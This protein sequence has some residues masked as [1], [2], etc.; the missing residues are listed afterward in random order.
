MP[1]EE[2]AFPC[3]ECACAAATTSG[4][5]LC[6][7]EWMQKAARLT[8]RLPSTTSP[9][10]STRIRSDT[11]IWLKLMPNGLTQNRSVNS[12]SRAV[13]CPA[14]PSEK[15]N[16]PNSR[17]A[18]AS[19]CFRCR[20][21]SAWVA[22]TGRDPEIP[23]GGGAVHSGHVGVLRCLLASLASSRAADLTAAC[24]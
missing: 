19:S 5:A 4:R 14:T 2:N 15:P 22:N 23:A 3:S 20:R 11:L 21:S 12:G 7:S 16:L 13:M 10:W 9:W 24:S 8:G 1:S 18:A 6:T 17:N